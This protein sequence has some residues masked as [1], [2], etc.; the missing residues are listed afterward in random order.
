MT[1]FFD[2]EEID[3][4]LTGL[5]LHQDSSI[6]LSLALGS[7][8]THCFY[9]ILWQ[10]SAHTTLRLVFLLQLLISKELPPQTETCFNTITSVWKKE[11][12]YLSLWKAQGG[13]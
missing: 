12:C 2:N 4:R 9:C 7:V 13:V 10:G 1:E 8:Y 3:H 6:Q 11:E 5:L